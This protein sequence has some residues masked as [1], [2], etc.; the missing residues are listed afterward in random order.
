MVRLMA[1]AIVVFI[2]FVVFRLYSNR[3]LSEIVVCDRCGNRMTRRRFKE[4]NGC[5]TCGSD[6]FRRVINVSGHTV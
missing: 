6:L 5:P 4:A 3:R 2:V 1:A